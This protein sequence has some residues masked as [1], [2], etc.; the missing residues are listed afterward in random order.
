[1]NDNT[2][3]HEHTGTMDAVT[4]ASDVIRHRVY[5][6]DTVTVFLCCG[7]MVNRVNRVKWSHVT[8]TDYNEMGN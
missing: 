3:K 4:N 6:L 1:M 2:N 8:I 5:T 7:S